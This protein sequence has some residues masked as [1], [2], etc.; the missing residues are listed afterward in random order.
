MPKIGRFDRW[1]GVALDK[2][3]YRRLRAVAKREGV[4]VSVLV[5]RYLG[6]CLDEDAAKA[7]AEVVAEAVRRAMA[8][9]EERL[10]KLALEA[11]ELGAAAVH[12]ALAAMEEKGVD[13]GE[14][15]RQARMRAVAFLGV[16]EDSH[17]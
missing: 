9:T 10:T 11:A 15:Y 6:R 17:E 4:P 5:R 2:D 1:L 8:S 7:G 3:L 12:L 14:L 16:E 13:T